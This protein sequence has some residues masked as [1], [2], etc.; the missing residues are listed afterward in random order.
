MTYVSRHEQNVWHRY[1]YTELKFTPKVN[2][3]LYK[4]LDNSFNDAKSLLPFSSTTFGRTTLRQ[5]TTAAT[6][7]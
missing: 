4:E 6:K 7:T 2:F 3:I 5:N 1:F